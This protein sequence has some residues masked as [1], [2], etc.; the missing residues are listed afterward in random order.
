MARRKLLIYGAVA[1]GGLVGALAFVP[2]LGFAQA[3]D[4]SPAPVATFGQWCAEDRGGPFA[5]AA[6]AIGIPEGDLH[7]AMGE[8]KTIADVARDN[9]VDIVVVD[10]IVATMRERLD[11]AVDNGFYSQDVADEIGGNFEDQVRAIVNGEFP[12]LP[13]LRGRPFPEHIEQPLGPDTPGWEWGALSTARSDGH[14]G[15]L[16]GGSCG[17]TLS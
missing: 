7:Y 15:R 13:G 14:K 5:V 12:M 1:M 10:A 8:G 4:E 17:R 9:D 3:D 16:P 2:S 6:E 11:T